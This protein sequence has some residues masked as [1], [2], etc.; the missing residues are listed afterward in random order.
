MEKRHSESIGKSYHKSRK[1]TRISTDN[2]LKMYEEIK[3]AYWVKTYDDTTKTNHVEIIARIEDDN[4]LYR[5][6]NSDDTEETIPYEELLKTRIG[7]WMLYGYEGNQN[8]QLLISDYRKQPIQ[9]SATILR[10]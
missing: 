4:L 2:K 10:E 7:S 6:A 1:Q 5:V 8:Q 3:E 9:I